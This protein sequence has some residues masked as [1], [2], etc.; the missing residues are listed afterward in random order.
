MFDKDENG[1]INKTEL[2]HVLVSMGDKLSTEDAEEFVKEA[3]TDKNG[4]INYMEFL[5]LLCDD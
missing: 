4:N 3:K 1:T 2:Q 5:H